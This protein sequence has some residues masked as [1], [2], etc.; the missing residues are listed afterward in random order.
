MKPKIKL[1]VSQLREL[2]EKHGLSNILNPSADDSQKMLTLDFLTDFVKTGTAHL[3]KGAPDVEDLDIKDLIA[4][5]K[6]WNEKDDEET[7]EGK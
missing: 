2:Q 5:F 6:G 7:P 4:I 1:K 3:G